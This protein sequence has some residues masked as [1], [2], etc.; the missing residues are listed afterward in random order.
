MGALFLL[1]FS[2]RL[3]SPFVAAFFIAA[4][5]QKII[6]FLDF[7]FGISR[8]ISSTILV[9]LIVV[10]II[11]LLFFAILQLMSQARNLIINLPS[12]ISALRVQFNLIIE[13]YNLFKLSLSPEISAFIDNV[14]AELIRYTSALSEKA[15][16]AALNVAKNFAAKLPN[17]LLFIVMFILSTFFFTKDYLLVINFFKELFPEKIIRLAT[18][19][20]TILF[21][22]FSSYMKAQLILMLLTTVLVTVS[23]WIVG[24]DYALLWGIV[25]G[26]TDALPI[27][28]TAVVLVPLALSSLVFGD[29]YSFVSLIIIQVLVFLVRQLAEPKVISHQIGI[30]PIL[31]LVSVY[32]GLKLFG[33]MGAVLAPIV[34]LLV[35]NLYVAYKEQKEF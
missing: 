23:L 26:L 6:R 22:A 9:T 28:G 15:G 8:G 1:P 16:S 31:T 7:K 34:T 35:V 2:L 17:L 13:K 27:L 25:C 18:K 12:T 19:T 4:L 11:A 3:L 33:I 20:K 10:S 24:Y 5:S 32:I 14:S 21:R 29:V 30:H